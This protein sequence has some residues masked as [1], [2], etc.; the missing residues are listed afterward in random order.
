MSGPACVS[1][2]AGPQAALL[3]HGA[4]GSTSSYLYS[5]GA[6]SQ[7]VLMRPARQSAQLPSAGFS[8]CVSARLVAAGGSR[9]R[10]PK[11]KLPGVGRVG[12]LQLLQRPG[13]NV[14][15]QW[16]ISGDTDSSHDTYM[17]DTDPCLGTNLFPAQISR[18]LLWA[19]CHAWAW[20]R[21]QCRLTPAP[22]NKH[23]NH[24]IAGRHLHA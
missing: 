2:F 8:E 6:A 5:A 9:H 24:P 21:S 3:T 10:A 17:N 18:K 16:C 20:L 15:R 19:V 14:R 23:M 12:C 13:P 11:V 22:V 7:P 4:S 1:A